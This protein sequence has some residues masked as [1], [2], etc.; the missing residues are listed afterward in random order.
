MIWIITTGGTIEGIDYT[1]ESENAGTLVSIQDILRNVNISV[2]YQIEN[3]FSKDSRFIS[4]EDRE[5]LKQKIVAVDANHILITHGT[6]TM[7][8]TATYLG[9]LDIDKTV[10]LVGSFILGN[11]KHSDATFN[12][13][14]A[15]GTLQNLDKGVYIVMNGNVFSWTNV[16]KNTDEN[17]FEKIRDLV[18]TVAILCIIVFV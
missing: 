4:H 16:I 9:K 7:V 13:G 2:K 6:V 8:E 15:L 17:R 5:L 1:N 12:L 11:E 3:A 18:L 10:V 14:F